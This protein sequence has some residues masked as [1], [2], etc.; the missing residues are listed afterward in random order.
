LQAPEAVETQSLMSKTSMQ[1]QMVPVSQAL[2]MEASGKGGMGQNE[3]GE[4]R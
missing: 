3:A 4:G 1:A 2:G